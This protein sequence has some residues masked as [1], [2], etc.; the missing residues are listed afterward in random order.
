[1]AGLPH[2]TRYIASS[3]KDDPIYRNLF[4]VHYITNDLNEEE[5]NILCVNTHKI[6]KRFI[7]LNIN[8][9]DSNGI[10]V[11]KHLTKLKN[12]SLKVLVYNK[13]GHIIGKFIYT[14]CTFPNLEE[15]MVD[16]SWDENDDI[17][18][19]KI[20]I[21]YE[22]LEYIDFDDF[23]RYERQKKLERLLKDE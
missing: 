9:N 12:F 14:D 16:F 19:P 13:I 5:R 3:Y 8:T 2:F 20:E 1:M 17:L 15:D 4:E 11:F 23:K 22:I 6:E 18:K 21:N 10:P 7:Y